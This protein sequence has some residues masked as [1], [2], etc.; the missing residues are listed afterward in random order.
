MKNIIILTS[1]FIFYQ[2]FQAT[3]CVAST[4]DDKNIRETNNK[5]KQNIEKQQR[6]QYLNNI[7]SQIN[8][9]NSNGNIQEMRKLEQERNDIII[10]KKDYK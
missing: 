2:I 6:Q 10:H 8:F 9:N 1:I 5:I 3:Q 7:D 4:L